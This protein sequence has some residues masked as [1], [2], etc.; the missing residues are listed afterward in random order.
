MVLCWRSS[1]LFFRCSLNLVLSLLC[2]RRYVYVVLFTLLPLH[3]YLYTTMQVLLFDNP[4]LNK[5]EV[6]GTGQKQSSAPSFRWQNVSPDEAC[7]VYYL[8]QFIVNQ[9]AIYETLLSQIDWQQRISM[10]GKNLLL[11]RLSAWYG[12]SDCH[13]AYS[14]IQLTPNPW[15]PLLLDLKAQIE[16]ACSAI[17]NCSLDFNSVLLNLYRD[18]RDSV[19]WHS[20]DE[21]EL[22]RQP[23]IASLSLG[24]SRRF[25]LRPNSRWQQKHPGEKTSS[26]HMDLVGGSLLL[27]AG[28]T[29][30]FWQHQVPKSSKPLQGRV[31]LTFRNIIPQVAER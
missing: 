10:Y 15:L 3:H 23:Q 7:D 14:G 29:Q 6:K 13:Y 5:P 4:Q 1:R 24:E 26:K 9:Q 8:S 20:D 17:C 2:L 31:N 16:A 25:S 22:G 18:G 21:A 11:P 12:D 28:Q 30:H 27:M 19:A